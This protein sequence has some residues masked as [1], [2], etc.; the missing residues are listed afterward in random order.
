MRSYIRDQIYKASKKRL[1][2]AILWIELSIPT[3]TDEGGW[4][5]I[6]DHATGV[7]EEAASMTIDGEAIAP[8][9]V[10]VTNHTFLANEDVE[11]EPSFGSL[12]TIGIPDFPI[13]RVA[14][15]E[16]LLE[17]YDKH[18]DVFAMMEG[19]RVGRAIPPTFDGTPGEFVAP[20]G[21][22]TRPIKIGDRILVPDEK[23][24]QV[25]VVVDELTSYRNNLAVAVRNE[26][27][28]QAW[29]YEMPLTEAERQAASRYTDAVFGKSNASRKLREDDPFDLYDW[30]RNA[31]S[32]TTPEQLAKLMEGPGWEPYRNFPTEEMRKRLA[33]QYTK[34]IWAQTREKKAKGQES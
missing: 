20:D 10:V 1:T 30:I 18:R 33:R 22:V 7:I 26:A 21:T 23:G 29:I 13:G 14:D 3:L 34:S 8:L 15:L 25:L 28:D 4:R 19:W 24:E 11:G 16:D 31:Y 17:G 6:I 5:T 2:N 12:H 9:F 27:T 32:R